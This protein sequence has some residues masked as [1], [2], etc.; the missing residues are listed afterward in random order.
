MKIL[1]YSIIHQ[2]ILL[3]TNIEINQKKIKLKI[4]KLF[5]ISLSKCLLKLNQLYMKKLKLMNLLNIVMQH[6]HKIIK[7]VNIILDKSK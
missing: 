4:L 6:I 1:T 2:E 3:I 5:T 7:K